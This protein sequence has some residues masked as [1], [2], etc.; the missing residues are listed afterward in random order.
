M[1]TIEG[2]A[3]WEAATRHGL[4][5][6]RITDEDV[7]HAPPPP[8]TVRYL[9]YQNCPR[10]A[11]IPN[12]PDALVE[13]D[14]Y[15]C[16]SLR[17]L[18]SLPASLFQLRVDYCPCLRSLPAL[19]AS[20]QHVGLWDCGVRNLPVLPAGFVGLNCSVCPQLRI[21]PQL[22][23]S[24]TRVVCMQCLALRAVWNLPA[25][26]AFLIVL[27][28]PQLRV[29]PALPASVNYLSYRR[30]LTMLVQIRSSVTSK[31]GN[32]QRLSC[33]PRRCCTC[34]NEYLTWRQWV[35]TRGRR[36][37][38]APG[39]VGACPRTGWCQKRLG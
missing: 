4:Y 37:C 7:I 21:L 26:I 8:A 22:P 39:A 29:L 6:L 33:R 11:S 14:V 32:A 30:R 17:A 25:G 23:A 9:S 38:T 27:H 1:C 13:L 16:P 35:C 15:K 24:V 19:P 18:P 31:T 5:R 36:L 10:L 34:R 3:A 20:I 12:L 2:V 28:C